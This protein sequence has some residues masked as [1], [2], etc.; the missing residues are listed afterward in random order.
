MAQ[1]STKIKMYAAANGV[2]EVAR[3]DTKEKKA[4]PL[5]GI[6][7]YISELL[8]EI[9]NNLFN[10]AKKFRDE[11]THKVDTWDDFVKV[12]EKGGFA[13]AH[14]DGTTET[15]LKIK[16]LTKATTRCIP[17]EPLPQFGMEG[18]GKCILT[19]KNSKQRI[20]FARAY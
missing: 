18:E 3:R 14:W 9:Q 4:I 8:E 20:L 1:L 2:A 10:R 13:Y 19:G 15:E 17:L 5:N 11:S 6:A 7:D 12:I 16:E